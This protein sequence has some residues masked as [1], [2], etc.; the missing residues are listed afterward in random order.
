VYEYIVAAI[1][2]LASFGFILIMTMRSIAERTREIGTLRAIGWQKPDV[3]KLITIESTAIAIIGTIMGIII[4]ILLPYLFQAM[5]PIVFQNIPVPPMTE[6]TKITFAT[7]IYAFI[8]GCTSGIIG[9]IVPALQASEM[10]PV[11]AFRAE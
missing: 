1:V 7:I 2:I 9:G 5:M 4:G 8:I 11:D 3:L 6:L 10:S